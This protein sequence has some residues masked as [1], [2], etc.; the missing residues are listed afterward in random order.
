MRMPDPRRLTRREF[1]TAVAAAAGLSLLPSVALAK[2]PA[3]QEPTGAPQTKPAQKASEPPSEEAVALA[4]IVKLRY[5]SRLDE[6][7]LQDITRSLDGGL[8]TAAALR[9][10]QLDNS[11][12][13]A[14][15]FK[16]LRGEH[17]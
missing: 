1:G 12:E 2:V 3:G 10:V 4:R 13:P 15:L 16:A 11:D 8:K 9:K 6:A 14:Y 5:G 7:A 17:D